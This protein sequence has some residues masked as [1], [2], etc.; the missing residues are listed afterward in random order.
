MRNPADF[1]WLAVLGALLVAIAGFAGETPAA[2]PEQEFLIT[3]LHINDV[4]GHIVPWVRDGRDSGGYARL[5]TA[6]AG[7]RAEGKAKRYFLVHGGDEF[8]VKTTLPQTAGTELTTRTKGEANIAVLNSLHFDVWVPGNGE[9]YNGLPSIKAR[10]REA[11]CSVLAAN[12]TLKENGQPLAKTF[13]IEQAGPVKVAFFGLCWVRPE[14]LTTVPL[15][16][17]DAVETARKLTPEL[18]QKADVV[19]AVTHIGLDHDRGLAAA[20]DGL[21][22]ILGAHSHNAVPNGEPAPTPSGRKTLICQA[23]DCLQ[24]L[25]R[26][27]MRLALKDG[28]WQVAETTAR[29]IPLDDK[30]VPDEATAKLIESLRVGR[31]TATTTGRKAPPVAPPA[32]EKVQAPA[33]K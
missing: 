17:G 7:I 26:V 3:F 22:L 14:T 1:R 28:K 18:R 16:L 5:A 15:A 20:V 25:G 33:N 4:H 10:I 32:P 2:K 24:Y 12:L 11:Q 30:V 29:L 21:D 9:F 19:V 8:S 13:V 27:D 6:V 23:G 31:G